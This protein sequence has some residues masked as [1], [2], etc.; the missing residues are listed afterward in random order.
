MKKY[1]PII[2]ILAIIKLS[3]QG[4]GNRN[5]GFHRDELL[6]LSV[7]EHLDWGFMEFPPFIGFIGR[8]SYWLF[9]YSLLGV[10]LFPTLAGVGILILCCLMAKELGG[11]SKAVFLAGICILAFLPFYRN[12]TL[13]QP[14]AFD[15]LFWTFGFYLVIKFTN[16]Q[17]KK[18]LILLGITLGLGLM[19]KYIILV[20]A[21]GL[22]MGLFFHQKGNLFKNKWLY[23]S[24]SISILIFL[25]NII[26]QAQNNFPILQHL[27]ALNASQLDDIDPMEFG[28]S[29]LE[30][31]FTLIISLFGLFALLLDKNL[32]NYRTVG[33]ASVVI[34]GTLWLLNSK[35]YY[36]FA[37]Y[38]VLFAAGA[39]KIESLLI[40][41]PIWIYVIAIVTLAPSIYFIPKLTP[42]LPM[43]TYVEYADLKEE[44][45]R[46][47]LT[48]DYADMFGWEEQVKL[49][50][51]VYRSLSTEEKNKCVL[52]AENYGEAGA[53]KILGKKYNLP[54]PIS[55]HGSFWT[56]GY[57]NK[58]AEVW[59]SLGNEKPSVEYVFEEVELVKM[60]T[61]KYAI[62]EENGIPLF[63][64][65]KPKVD[66]QKWWQDYEEHI[67][68]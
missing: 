9:D 58:E 62:G 25:P 42:I 15:Q 3:I 13:F 1:F 18:F 7:S 40:K 17:N 28:L 53:L 55:R 39:V 61:H 29:Q 32:K 22:C 5:Y 11:K 35:A 34:F 33:I 64:C 2:L 46:I 56:W 59:I 31:P 16:T 60:I 37:L 65:R 49:V 26:W 44:N 66:I 50:D 45:G 48:G 30:Y 52:W 19:N 21:F 54:N 63:I 14:V 20:W 51:S 24:V 12:H 68:D 27:Q 57:G 43:E 36:V 38:P 8:I 10:R 47:E 41:K 67:F 4:F 6:H 23:I